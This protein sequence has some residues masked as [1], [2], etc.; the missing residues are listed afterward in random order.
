MRVRQRPFLLRSCARQPSARFSCHDL[1]VAAES[2]LP[3]PLSKVGTTQVALLTAGRDKPYALGL[4]VALLE[5]GVSFEFLGSDD[6]DSPTLH[7]NPHIVF[8]NIRGDQSEDAP[9]HKKV[10]RVLTYYRRLIAYAVKAQPRIFHILWNNRFE[11]FDRTVL[12]AFYRM[13]GRRLILTAHNVNAGNRDGTDS[14]INRLTLR[15]Q[16]SLTDHIFVH[17]E[18]MRD[19][20]KRGFGVTPDKISVIPFGM[21][22][23]VPDTNMDRS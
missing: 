17:T 19:D 18:R 3:E 23:T 4:A 11:W 5:A 7:G 9:L 8:H 21:N 10:S 15:I 1:K 12:M 2:R 22:S 14:F 6:V 16:Y 13:C 20:L